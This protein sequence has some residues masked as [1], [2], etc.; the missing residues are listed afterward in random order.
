ML[1]NIGLAID[2]NRQWNL[3]DDKAEYILEEYLKSYH[4]KLKPKKIPKK[5]LDKRLK[6]LFDD[7]TQEW[8]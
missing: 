2:D 4:G 6:H 8:T 7:K 1:I 3:E 5:E